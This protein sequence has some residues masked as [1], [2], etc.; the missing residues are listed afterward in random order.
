MT[1]GMTL[2][3]SIDPADVVK[4]RRMPV[5][6]TWSTPVSRKLVSTYYD[7]PD[8]ALRHA[9]NELRVHLAGR[10]RI[11]TIQCGDTKHTELHQG[12]EYE[13]RIT[14]ATSDLGKITDHALLKL[15]SHLALDDRLCSLQGDAISGRNGAD[16]EGISSAV[17]FLEKLNNHRLKPVVITL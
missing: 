1:T 3:F 15:F 14:R 7:T 17:A 13:S 16:L 6:K 5:L 8:L 4:L 11:Q 9:G 12:M 2:K 10:R